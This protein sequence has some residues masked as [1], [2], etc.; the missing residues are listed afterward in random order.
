MAICKEWIEVT[1]KNYLHETKKGELFTEGESSTEEAASTEERSSKQGKSPTEGL[2]AN[3][4]FSKPEML[5]EYK[6]LKRHT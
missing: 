4:N 3:Y 2:Q 1:T 5:K 6:C